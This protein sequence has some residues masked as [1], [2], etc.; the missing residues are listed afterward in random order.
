MT[1][2]LYVRVVNLLGP[3]GGGG[4][5]GNSGRLV[6]P[7]S[8]VSTSAPPSAMGRGVGSVGWSLQWRRARDWGMET[9]I[10]FHLKVYIRWSC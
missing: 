2:V 9:R 6:L 4:L 5:D 7:S 3:G 1:F 10:F 8:G